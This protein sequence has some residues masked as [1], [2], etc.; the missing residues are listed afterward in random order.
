MR[1]SAT[2][3]C[4]RTSS[5]SGPTAEDVGPEGT[6]AAYAAAFGAAGLD[7]EALEPAEFARR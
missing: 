2:P 1:P 4:D 5:R 3:S 7:L 6:D